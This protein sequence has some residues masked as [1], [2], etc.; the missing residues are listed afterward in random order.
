M[1]VSSILTDRMS[2]ARTTSS[3]ESTLTFPSSRILHLGTIFDNAG[4]R[5]HLQGISVD[6]DELLS[7]IWILE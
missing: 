3:V 1:S 4:A 2:A 6:S 5:R 7:G